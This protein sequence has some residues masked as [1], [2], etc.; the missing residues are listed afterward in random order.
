M[1]DQSIVHS[2]M[3]QGVPGAVMGV[4]Q[5]KFDDAADVTYSTKPDNQLMAL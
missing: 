3:V 4:G 2:T 1:T 5:G